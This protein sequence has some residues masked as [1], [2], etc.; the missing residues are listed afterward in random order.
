MTAVSGIS[1]LRE[2]VRTSWRILLKEITAF[3]AIG[4]VA[5]VI[6]LSLYNLL[7]PHG[8]LKAKCAAT[9][10]ATIFAYFGNRHLSFSHRARTSIGRETSF[11]FGINMIALLF[12]EVVL[13]VF[14]YPLNQRDDH[15][16]MN[17]VNLVTIAIGTV[18]RF[19]SYKRFVFQ[20]PDRV[21]SKNVDLDEELAE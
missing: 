17:A 20:H 16:V 19:W 18:F 13:A 7:A 2:H 4:L 10:V 8:W 5:L 6:D 21:H 14:A 9:V 12:A 3:G 1:S 11:F 15:F